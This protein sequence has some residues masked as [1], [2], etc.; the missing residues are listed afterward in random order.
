MKTL[1]SHR[2]AACIA[3]VAAAAALL[4]ACDG[5]DMHGAAA[6][7]AARAPLGPASSV[8]TPTLDDG[9]CGGHGV[10]ESVCTRCNGS[11]IARFKQAGDWC[12]EHELPESQCVKCHPEVARRWAA[13]DPDAKPAAEQPAAPI[14]EPVAAASPSPPDR[15]CFDHG[16][17]KDVC[18]RCDPSLIE[19]FKEANDWCGEHGLPESQCALC[20]PEVREKWAA[21]RPAAPSPRPSASD[22]VVM[23]ERDGRRRPVGEND[24]LC[25][26][27]NSIIRLRDPGIARQAGIETAT[28]Q[29]RPM[30][31][32]V[33]VPAEIEF[34]ATRVARITPRVPGI[35]L[36]VRARLGDTV[37]AGDVLAVIDSTLLGDA[38][39]HYIERRQDLLVAE[40]EYK[41]V[42]TLLDGARRL[43][44]VATA[45][46]KPD[47]I[48]RHLE[49]V[50][51]GEPRA[52]LL[53]A[54][55]ALRLARFDAER[56][57]ELYEKNMS[58]E[59]DLQ[60]AQAA[61]A[62]AEAE[63]RAIREEIALAS[64]KERVAAE[65][66]VQV[67]RSALEAVRRRL[68]ILGVSDGEIAALATEHHGH[69]TRYELRS[70]VAGRIIERNVTTGEAVEN[71]QSLF[72][73]AD[74]STL[75]LLADVN[76]RD[77]PLLR[78]GQPVQFT[79]DGVPGEA[80]DARL[81]W[82]SSQV[83]DKTRLAS[84]RAELANP[85]G[86]LRAHMF[87]R[88]RIVVRDSDQAL[89]VPIDSIQTDGCCQ[90]AFVRTAADTF[91]P[92]KVRLGVQTGGYAE[93]LRGLQESEAVVTAG[94]FLMKT[95]ILK[96][97]IGAGCCEVDPGR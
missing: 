12:A 32:T 2:R 46:A 93:V 49:G 48:R 64:E 9:W 1:H 81:S 10:P 30:S 42:R 77:L 87:G 33:Q 76:E 74:T 38:K 78:E 72:V 95:E 29:R 52:R 67:A 3:L 24:P 75:W 60:T 92:R 20:N 23:I 22:S 94:S 45:D 91:E 62:A 57:V 66:S 41:R 88:A 16:V 96:G 7:G 56:E 90:L 11:L 6:R 68:Q 43:L 35:A 84:V 17:L 39:S 47:E 71:S 70:P 19:R 89:S 36:E 82:I 14:A 83:D 13:L 65:R 26:I 50:P 80:F 4:A 51:V 61:L 25:Q 86:A 5:Q 44:E 28:V 21:V 73:V 27:E 97:N 55:A 69:L 63:F 59:K 8:I 40:A 37:H 34:D 53:R 54:H 31:A 85:E 79:V 18:T 15:W 58:P